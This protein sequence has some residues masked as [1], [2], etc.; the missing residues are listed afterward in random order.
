MADI[1]VE[2]KYVITMDQE[3]RI[4]KN[5]S[6]V[7]EDGSIVDVGKS[8]EIEKK[9]TA[10]RTISGD[11][12]MVIPG[13]VD[14]HTHVFQCLFRGLGD[15]M[16]GEQWFFKSTLGMSRVA[17]KED[18]YWAAKLNAC[19]MIRTGTTAFAD[20][21]YIHIDRHTI[22]RIA[23]GTL[24]SGMRALIVRATQNK[25]DPEEFLEDIET[26]KKETRRVHKKYDG[27]E[28]RLTVVPEVLTLAEG[29]E[30]FIIEMKALADELGNGMHMHVGEN[31]CEHNYIKAER[32]MGEVE[33]LEKLGVLD[34]N[35]LMAHAIWLSK[36]EILSVKKAN[37]KVAHNAVTNQWSAGGIADIPLMRALGITVGIGCDGPSSNNNQDM[38]RAMKSCA[39]MHH[40]NSFSSTAITAEDVLEMATIDGAKALRIDDKVG[41]IEAGKRA[42]LAV[43]DLAK[44][45][46][47]PCARPVSNLVYSADGHDIVTTIVDGKILM[48][49]R[50]I[51]TVDERE[52]IEKIDKITKRLAEKSG[53]D[54][55]YEERDRF[56][57]V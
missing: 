6:V 23:D 49:N 19:D 28:G 55:F 36:K 8:K 52:V 1:I 47:S 5:G 57:V 21:H 20:S 24:E 43:I 37:A 35:F 4:I 30:E 51:Q 53:I 22:D 42:D 25:Y 40:L 26:A 32:N 44:P 9:Y 54:K 46:L 14:T 45:H 11:K 17:T 33:Y 7:I 31:L 29:T 41:S 12:Y 38:I 18:F 27:K 16:F 13:L 48:E 2:G 15:E 50:V 10:N 34:E 3:R 39:L 56:K